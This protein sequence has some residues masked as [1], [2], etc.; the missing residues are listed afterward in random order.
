MKNQLVTTMSF[1]AIIL[2][3]IVGWIV[4]GDLPDGLLAIASAAAGYMGKTLTGNR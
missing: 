1:A 2:T 4:R 3:V